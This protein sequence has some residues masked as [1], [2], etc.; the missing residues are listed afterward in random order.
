[1]QAK[2]AKEFYKALVSL[3]ELF[4]KSLTANVQELYFAALA[5]LSL[6]DAREACKR[7][8]QQCKFFPKP[9][10][11]RELVSGTGSEQADQAWEWLLGA[12]RDGAGQYHSCF[13][14]DGA[15]A[16][17]ITRCW[18]GI[19]EA[20]NALRSLGPDEPMYA[21]QRKS[22]VAA[23]TSCL[24]EQCSPR[25]FAGISELANRCMSFPRDYQQPVVLI[26]TRGVATLSMPFNGAT[27]E[28]QP[29][30]KQALLDCDRAALRAYL[31]GKT[32]LALPPATE[33]T[34]ELAPMPDEVREG[35]T[36]L[37]IRKAMPKATDAELMQK[38]VNEGRPF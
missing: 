13:V 12:L 29:E 17:A 5:D 35:I 23:Y 15:L 21:S 7:A 8:S 4:D 32:A 14:E 6:D 27:G 9:V 22:Y 30:A 20:F 37:A 38:P 34:A 10:E 28:L 3:A 18:G 26:G 1:M 11:L 2:Q 24:R 19:V 36:K 25:Y 16:A 31:P 33:E